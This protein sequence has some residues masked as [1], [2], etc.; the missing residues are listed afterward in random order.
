MADKKVDIKI[1]AHVEVGEMRKLEDALQR[2]IVQL[3]LAGAEMDKLSAKEAR[4]GDLRKKI[5]A[6]PVGRRSS[7]ALNEA[8]QSIPGVGPIFSAVN[9]SAL[10]IAAGIAVVTKAFS[11]AGD[12]VRAFAASEVEMAKLDAALANSGNL[13]DAY[14]EKLSKLATTRSGKTGI[15]DEKYIGVFTTL[16]KFGADT[17][18]IDAYTTAVENLAGFMGG[19]LEQAAF[20]FGKAMQGST[21]MLGRYGIS[22]D[23]SKSQTEQLA[24]IMQQLQARG[25]GQLEAMANTLDGSFKKLSNS[26]ENLLESFGSLAEKAG[27]ANYF[28]R[29]A[30]GL[31]II[32]DKIGGGSASKSNNRVELVGATADEQKTADEIAVKRKELEA[33]KLRTQKDSAQAFD[34][35]G[36][37]TDGPI[38]LLGEA[39]R[40]RREDLDTRIGSND[41]TIEQINA[42]LGAL[43]AKEKELKLRRVTPEEAATSRAIQDQQRGTVEFSP[44]GNPE[45]IAQAKANA[46]ELVA[47]RESLDLELQIA[48]AVASGDKAAESKLK[49]QKD[50]NAA[51]QAGLAAQDPNA[52]NNAIR[53]ANAGMGKSES[54]R[55]SGPLA[56]RLSQIGGYNGGSVLASSSAQAAANIARWTEKTAIGVE[57]LVSKPGLLQPVTNTF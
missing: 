48:E 22:V 44:G 37:F 56:D 18:N 45:A 46:E 53:G 5:A 19:D 14:R 21:E 28:S 20:L 1:Q 40:K 39:D 7:A 4:L 51:L 13:T 10:G 23:K 38:N 55:H 36:G 17:S 26:W 11:L 8:A 54:F 49:W 50:Y 30:E 24:D 33:S 12:A 2:E 47:K 15:D 34:E 29:F 52:W 43:D 25:G 3:R 16:T 57:K 27:L 42:A 41:N 32:A 31:Q 9:G 35:L 6:V